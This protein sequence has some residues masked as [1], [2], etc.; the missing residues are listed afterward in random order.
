MADEFKETTTQSWGSRLGDSVKGVLVGLVLFVASFVVLFWGEGRAVRDAKR[1]EDASKAVVSIK[2]DK[3]E[4]AHEGKLV[5]TSGQAVTSDVLGDADFGISANAIK[6]VRS[7][8]MY[9]WVEDKTTTKKKNVGGSETSETSYSY[10][11]V[12]FPGA[13]DSARFNQQAGHENP[14]AAFASVEQAAK[15]VA[16]GAFTLPAELIAKINNLQPHP[17]TQGDLARVPEN[18]RGRARLDSGAIYL[19]VARAPGVPTQPDVLPQIGDLRVRFQD[20]PPGPVSIIAR[21]IG[22]T[23]E[24]Y[25]DPNNQTTYL[26]ST[27]TKSAAAMFAAE[28][29]KNRMFT[30]LTRIGGFVLMFIGLTMVLKPLSVVGDVLP[31]LGDLIGMGAGIVAFIVS[32]VLSLITIAIAWLFFRPVLG[33]ILLVVAIGLIVLAKKYLRKPKPAAQS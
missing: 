29:D 6:L 10:K 22:S 15:A 30:W 24:P 14:S 7:V 32:L 26:L 17:A 13:V 9:Q 33:I 21:Q 8:E 19:P 1:I 2:S 12:W 27:G 3:V 23:F 18:Y 25:T 11:K 20:A 5:H 16:V 28:A 4:S 31:L